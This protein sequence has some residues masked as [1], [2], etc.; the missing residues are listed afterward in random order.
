MKRRKKHK[1]LLKTLRSPMAKTCTQE[2]NR[3]ATCAEKIP[4]VATRGRCQKKEEAKK[5]H[6]ED[7]SV[8]TDVKT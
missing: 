6:K 7:D 1:F 8:L 2:Y 4:S 3:Y 5:T